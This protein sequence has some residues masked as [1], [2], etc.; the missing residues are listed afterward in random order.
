MTDQDW[1]LVQLVH[2]RGSYKVCKAAWP[3]FVKQKYGRIINTASAAGIYGN[4][5]QANYSAGRLIQFS[6]NNHSNIN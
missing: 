6:V 3:Y 2:L 4:Y 5:G 1:D